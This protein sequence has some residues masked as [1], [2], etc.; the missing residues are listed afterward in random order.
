MKEKTGKIQGE[1]RS[2]RE[3]I[4][5]N[6]SLIS[7]QEDDKYIIFCPALDIC[8]SGNTESEAEESL[9]ITLGEFM[10]YTTRKKTLTSELKRMGWIIKKSQRK[11]MTPPPM[12]H[13]LEH[14]E[15]FNRIFNEFPFRKFD[16]AVEVP[17]C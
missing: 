3:Q 7:F 9:N 11:P 8:G 16:K 10:L 15:E 5:I 1:W 17:V 14:N 4:M 6:L 2:S 13:L 12:S